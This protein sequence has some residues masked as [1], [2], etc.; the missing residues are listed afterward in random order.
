MQNI[1]HLLGIAL[2]L[3]HILIYLN[4]IYTCYF[5]LKSID[6]NLRIC[7]N[8]QKWQKAENFVLDHTI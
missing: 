5:T 8:I 6:L 4:F 2:I 7:Q 1:Q 3:S